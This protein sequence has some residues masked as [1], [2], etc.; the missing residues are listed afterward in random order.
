MSALTAV[1]LVLTAGSGRGAT[2][3]HTALYIGGSVLIALIGV[4]AA[5]LRRRR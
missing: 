1:A 2:G 5:A 4:G 3:H